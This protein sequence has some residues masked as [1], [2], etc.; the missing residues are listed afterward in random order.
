MFSFSNRHGLN[1]NHKYLNYNS[2]VSTV[3][4]KNV[5]H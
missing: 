2:F 5:M 4:I 1:E 3:K